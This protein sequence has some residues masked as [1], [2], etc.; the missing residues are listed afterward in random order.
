MKSTRKISLALTI[1]F[2]LLGSFFVKGLDSKPIE[3][4]DSETLS[5]LSSEVLKALNKKQKEVDSLR[6]ELFL[7]G[8]EK[9]SSPESETIENK[10]NQIQQ[11][12]QKLDDQ[13]HKLYNETKQKLQ[14]LDSQHKEKKEKK[15]Q[16]F[17]SNKEKYYKQ[18]K[19]LDNKRKSEERKVGNLEAFCSYNM[20]EKRRSLEK[21]RGI[22]SFGTTTIYC[23]I[24]NIRIE[25]GDKTIPDDKRNQLNNKLNLLYGMLNLL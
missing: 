22:K 2:L 16:E 17:R 20:Y 9:G 23:K 3:V 21:N 5:A 13:R 12:I 15:I 10:I 24:I 25:L 14:G 8:G 18:I 11:E 7:L 19:E 4:D 1:F 6:L